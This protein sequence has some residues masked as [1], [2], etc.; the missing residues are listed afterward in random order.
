M[1]AVLKGQTAQVSKGQ[2]SLLSEVQEGEAGL[3]IFR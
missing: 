3:P 1:N 2:E